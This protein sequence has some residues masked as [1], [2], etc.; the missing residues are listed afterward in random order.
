MDVLLA[1]VDDFAP[2]AI[3]ERPEALRVFFPS[4][5]VRDSARAALIA[6]NYPTAS[7]DVDDEDWARRSQQHLQPVTVEFSPDDLHAGVLPPADVV[8]A[9]LIGALLVRAA[10]P[11]ASAVRP[12]GTLIVSG[13]LID[14]K[15]AVLDAFAPARATWERTEE[16][17]VGLAFEFPAVK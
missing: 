14:E 1:I 3:E 12:G 4:P 8:V 10:R 7:V 9:N 15:A 5:T 6:A 11:L 13:L 17:W 16:E 2:T